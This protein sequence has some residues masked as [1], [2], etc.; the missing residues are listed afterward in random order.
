MGVP[1]QPFSLPVAAPVPMRQP[2][3]AHGLAPIWV[4][5]TQARLLSYGCGP[6][7]DDV[8]WMWRWSSDG[9]LHLYRTGS[10]FEC[11]RIEMSPRANVP[12]SDGWV[13]GEVWYEGDSSR[14]EGGD[15]AG[16]TKSTLL[17][18]VDLLPDL[19]GLPA[20]RLAATARTR[21]EPSSGPPLELLAD[22]V[23]SCLPANL[24]ELTVGDFSVDLPA[25]CTVLDAEADGDCLRLTFSDG[26]DLWLEHPGDLD[27]DAGGITGWHGGLYVAAN[28]RTWAVMT[29]N[30]LASWGFWQEF[31]D[32]Q[33]PVFAR[34][35]LI[36]GGSTEFSSPFD[37]EYRRNDA[38]LFRLDWSM[39]RPPTSAHEPR[40][41]SSSEGQAP[42]RGA[43][44]LEAA[45]QPPV[46]PGWHVFVAQRF[47][48]AQSWWLATELAR[49]HPNL[50][51]IETH[52]GDGQYDC[53][54]LMRDGKPLVW[55]NRGGSIL[56][57]DRDMSM[58]LAGVFSDDDPATAIQAIEEATGL[59]V[60]RHAPATGPRTLAYR[61]AAQLT[62]LTVN[63]RHPVDVRSEYNDT[64]GGDAGGR[65]GLIR[66]FPIAEAR[67]AELR[68]DDLHGIP[69]YRYW[70]VLRNQEPI[71]ALDTDGFAYLD[72]HV[73][74][75]PALYASNGRNLTA[76]VTQTFAG[77]L[78]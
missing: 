9:V 23:R 11:L 75:L 35:G 21:R 64:S 70:A 39:S 51:I 27:V 25:A 69:G 7:H 12:E 34:A 45:T 15:P 37:A 30:E 16:L 13:T 36:D 4:S 42:R 18:V 78:R 50:L 58:P 66:G 65:R 5:S 46:M 72:E 22:R 26:A 14:C 29:D 61:V 74:H 67:A 3:L 59:G 53:L 43:P 71:A 1:W 47:Q 55:I 60:P 2:T 48:V 68:P 8:P 38:P 57:E 56:L 28:P 31:V 33:Y 17:A 49:R 62:M 19:E 40:T 41:E 54:T 6:C 20:S 10:G 63:D 52:P 73:Y 76:L 24:D 77:I 32:G 44:S